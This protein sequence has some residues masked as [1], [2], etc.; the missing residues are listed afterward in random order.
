MY[1]DVDTILSWT[2]GYIK[3]YDECL[4]ANKLGKTLDEY[5]GGVS[6][7]LQLQANMHSISNMD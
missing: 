5:I 7:K 4:A 6:L 2:G 1:V 3:S